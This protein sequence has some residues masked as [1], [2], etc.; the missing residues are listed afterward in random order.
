MYR[1]WSQMKEGW[2]KNLALLFP[3]PGKLAFVQ[4]VMLVGLTATAAMTIF[5]LGLGKM[6]QLWPAWLW[7]EWSWRCGF[8]IPHGT[9]FL[10]ISAYLF[11]RTRKAGFS[12]TSAILAPIGVA[13]FSF[14]LLRS[15]YFY[16]RGRLNWRDRTYVYSM[17]EIERIKGMGDSATLTRWPS[18]RKIASQRP[19]KS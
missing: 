15:K 9:A 4:L 5:S 2:T 17:E 14:L 7:P 8:A 6:P 10:L 19:V 16:G 12:V 13:M 1:S 11:V 18:D 3:K